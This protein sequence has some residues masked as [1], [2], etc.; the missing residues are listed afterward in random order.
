M[1][2]A[3]PRSEHPAEL[4]ARQLFDTQAVSYAERFTRQSVE[5]LL[6]YARSAPTAMAAE[7]APEEYKPVSSSHKLSLALELSKTLDSEQIASLQAND[8]WL[9]EDG[10]SI[11]AQQLIRSIQ[12]AA[13]HGLNP[14]SYGL[15]EI[16]RTVDTLS[17][18][19]RTGAGA[20]K[21]QHGVH[22]PGSLSLRELLGR[23]MDQAFVGLVQHLGQGVVDARATQKDLFRD[24]PAINAQAQLESVRSGRSSALQAL[25]SVTPTH[26]DYQRLT[27]RMRDLLTE[28]AS[29]IRR[30]TIEHH[31]SASS[32][33]SHAD[34]Y[35]IKSRLVDTGDLSPKGTVMPYFDQELTNALRRFQQRHG[36]KASGRL[37]LRT[38]QVLNLSIEEEIRAIALSLERWRWMPR[39]L[40]DK[41]IFINIPDYHVV[42]RDGDETLLN[43]TAVVGSVEHQTPTFSRDMSYMEFNPTW[44]V[45]ASIANR[46]LIPKERRQ[47]GYLVSRQFDF[48]KRD[49]K[50]LVVVPPEEVTAAD[51]NMERFP[52]LLRQRG[53]PINALGRMKFMMPNPYAIYLHDTQAKKHFTLNDRAYSHGCIRLSDPDALAI[54]LMQMDGY[55]QDTI[56]KSL[57]GS[58]TKRVRLRSPVPTHLTYLTTW[59]DE[60]GELQ[61][62]ADIY[63]QDAALVKALQEA[64]TLLSLLKGPSETDTTLQKLA[65]N[66]S[67]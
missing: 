56:D 32:M 5:P 41:H 15:A 48:L 62:R 34:I 59:V 46:E 39:K 19:D 38:R 57:Q 29:G 47:P 22:L 26:A 30:K 66:E 36:L 52:Y 1:A 42:V 18:L 21:L 31:T 8:P 64:G 63:H 65:S 54:L 35:A 58:E 3:D 23:Q 9:T 12:N 7:H 11:N 60:A 33:L 43:M 25:N 49:G 17:G 27:R 2:L 13:I 16:L 53:G 14:D 24:V 20:G 50:Q 4:S 61:R 55:S 37:D 10:L 6:A 45:P 40:G 44:T 28:H 67:R 51:F